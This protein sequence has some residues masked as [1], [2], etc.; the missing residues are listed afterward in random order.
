MAVPD[1]GIAAAFGHEAGVVQASAAIGDGA[2]HIQ[3]LDRAVNHIAEGSDWGILT[4]SEI[5]RNGMAA[6]QEDTTE[7]LERIQG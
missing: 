7:G 1:C 4:C 3:V 2:L 5:E 6:A